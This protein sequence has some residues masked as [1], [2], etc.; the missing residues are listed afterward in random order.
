MD[1][2]LISPYRPTGDQPEAIDELSRGILDGTPYQTLL[3]VTGSGKTFTMANV[4]E[5]VQKPTLILSHNKTLAAQL[6]NEFK[7]HITIIINRRLIYPRPTLIS[8]RT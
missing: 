1:F 6:Y 7:S 5:R 4:I 2:K 3:G 8:K